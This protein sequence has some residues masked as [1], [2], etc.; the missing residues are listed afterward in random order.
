MANYYFDGN[1][2][3]NGVGT[4]LDPF[5]VI[6]GAT[7]G[8]T[9]GDR[10]LFKTGTIVKVTASAR[11]FSRGNVNAQI[12]FGKY[13]AN[14]T[15]GPSAIGSNPILDNPDSVGTM[16][17]NAAG[18]QYWTIE[19]IWFRNT[20]SSITNC[21]Y[22]AVQGT[23]PLPGAGTIIGIIIRRCWFS[24][25]KGVGLNCAYESTSQVESQKI[26]IEDCHFFNNG[27]HGL[28]MS[29]V[30][31]EIRRCYAY[32]NGAL[33][34]PGGSHGISLQAGMLST[35]AFNSGWTNTA[36]TIY[37]R[38]LTATE[39][40]TT[41][42]LFPGAPYNLR[43]SSVA[44]YSGINLIRNDAAGV[45]PGTLEYS[46]VGTTLYVN[47]GVAFTSG[48][49]IFANRPTI[50]C[51][52]ED[53]VCYNN[54]NLITN[55]FVEG[56]GL[57]LDDFASNCTV[58]RNRLYNNM[59]VGISVNAGNS[60]VLYANVIYGNA[61]YGIG[62]SGRN[63]I[64]NQNTVSKNNDHKVSYFANTNGVEIEC[65]NGSGCVVNQN[66]VIGGDYAT[67]GINT[68]AGA[69]VD[70]NVVFGAFSAVSNIAT[71]NTIISNPIL[72]SN[73]EM[74]ALSPA[75]YAGVMSEYTKCFDGHM[76]NNPPSIG[77]FE[78]IIPRG[79]RA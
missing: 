3:T 6:D 64:I 56:H 72:N 62:A 76:Y 14:G 4:F 29:G 25:S 21:I 32:N 33:V 48:S 60:N 71:T 70:R 5:N 23:T 12:Y 1:S 65:S 47:L 20:G 41:T 50:N 44:G 73:Y 57:A 9:A 43:G 26:I 22:M 28:Y 54:I 52:L 7:T 59:G 36:G 35:Y 40:A 10:F 75:K 67:T 46:V 37:S 17:L 15:I 55:T 66:I 30:G 11:T 13:D 53:N 39:Q 79:A 69:T 77:A 63:H 31:H 8:G 18:R 49:V 34:T 68:H 78:Y 27:G 74:S 61:R 2:P 38:T 51:I 16:I 24:G 58:R 45:S 19:D 42:S